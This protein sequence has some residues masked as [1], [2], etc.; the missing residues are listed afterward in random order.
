MLVTTPTNMSHYHVHVYMYTY[1]YIYISV[2][3]IVHIHVHVCNDN[4][5]MFPSIYSRILILTLVILDS[6]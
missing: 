3:Y 1:M 5:H 2:C 6:P 4:F